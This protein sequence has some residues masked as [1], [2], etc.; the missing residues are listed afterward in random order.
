MEDDQFSESAKNKLQLKGGYGG[1]HPS[2]GNRHDIMFGKDSYGVK[3][4]LPTYVNKHDFLACYCFRDL[5]YLVMCQY[6]R[7]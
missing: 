6:L 3:M 1:N 2:R 7:K 5:S 4:R